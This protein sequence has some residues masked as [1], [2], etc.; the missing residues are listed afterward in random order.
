MGA[1]DIG[2]I[3]MIRLSF[4]YLSQ[5]QTGICDTLVEEAGQ[6]SETGD[7]SDKYE[8]ISVLQ[9]EMKREADKVSQI[10]MATELY[11][12]VLDRYRYG[13]ENGW[14]N[15]QNISANI[16]ENSSLVVSDIGFAV[17]DV[18]NDGIMELLVSLMNEDGIGRIVEDIYTLDGNK[19]VWLNGSGSNKCYL[20]EDGD[21]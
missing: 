4:D 8:L 17:V 10:K 14:T 5:V 3:A 9:T 12:E 19:P 20:H 1:M 16:F 15:T 2:C 7:F 18:N 11:G 21:I 6:E 13:I